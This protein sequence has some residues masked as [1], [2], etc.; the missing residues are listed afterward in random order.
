MRLLRHVLRNVNL[1]NLLLV[2]AVVLL[3]IHVF[4]FLSM[5]VTYKTPTLKETPGAQEEK[6]ATTQS[7]PAADYVVIAEQNIFHP[8]RKIPPENKD[9][10]EKPKAEF[11]LYGTL[12]ADGMRLAYLEDKKSPQSTPGRGKRQSVVKQGEVVSGYLLKSVEADRIVLVR[13]EEQIVA[14]VND[15]KRQREGVTSD[16]ILR[17]GSMAPLPRP[18]VAAQPSR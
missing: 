10:K 9:E 13:G 15:P 5:K 3:A 6:P 16:G 8:E 4:P 12:L 1:L 17:A 11:V 14:L 18:A 2:A 7:P